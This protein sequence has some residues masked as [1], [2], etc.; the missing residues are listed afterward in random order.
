MFRRISALAAG[1]AIVLAATIPPSAADSTSNV[2]GYDWPDGFGSNSWSCLA[3]QYAPESRDLVR[4]G[5]VP[6]GNAGV[7]SVGWQAA[8]TNR[9]KGLFAYVT[10]PR[11][12]TVFE[13]AVY[14][15]SGHS[16]GHVIAVYN[17]TTPGYTTG[18]WVGSAAVTHNLADWGV[19]N[20]A[21]TQLTWNYYANGAYVTTL[22]PSSVQQFANSRA[23]GG[24]A[25]VGV[26]WG[27]SGE[28][29]YADRLRV[30]SAGNVT[31]YNVEGTH[32]QAIIYGQ[33]NAKSDLQTLRIPY[34]QKL[35]VVGDMVDGP[36]LDAGTLQYVSGPGTL[37]QKPFGA[38]SYK[39][40]TS[41]WAYSDCAS[42][43]VYKL[44]QPAHQT[45]YAF[46]SAPSW[47]WGSSSWRLRVE[48]RAIVRA[49][50]TDRTLRK[51]QTIEVKGAIQP[52]NRGIRVLLQAKTG[53]WKK[54]D[55]ARTRR[56]GRFTLRAPAR[57]LGTYPVR[58]IVKPGK[59]NL[60]TKSKGV[61]ITVKPRPPVE[62]NPV[63]P[64]VDSPDVYIPAAP[65]P[66]YHDGRVLPR[67]VLLAR[68]IGKQPWISPDLGTAR[69]TITARPSFTTAWDTFL[70]R[71]L[72]ELPTGSVAGAPVKGG[73][74]AP[75]QTVPLD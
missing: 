12:L 7:E 22:G 41:G 72:R 6:G 28:A 39:T 57:K 20:A 48:V 27:C 58:V 24:I 14:A 16:T 11:A 33:T 3:D 69:P 73:G 17:D 9:E 60:G 1:L 44:V 52:K 2:Y 67:M 25:Q 70:A 64:P 35:W 56:G 66:N 10:N 26:A 23:A 31:T 59:G 37:F 63:S 40:L 43:V 13:S 50:L 32:D 68:P 51:G 4:T 71:A 74:A 49:K 21:T 47:I 54:I 34:G 15:P 75:V 38:A 42:C 19:L 55:A 61:S 62:T 5:T 65:E 53:G 30:G 29:V 18:L 36:L 46:Q 8:V 45:D